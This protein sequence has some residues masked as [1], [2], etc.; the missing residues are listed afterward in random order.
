M[1]TYKVIIFDLF[2]TIV[3]FNRSR[4]PVTELNG[5][6]IN[7]TSPAVYKVFKKYCNHV[8]FDDFYSA[9][10]KSY[11]E[12]EEMKRKENLEF[13]NKERFK[14]MLDK[15]NI[16]ANSDSNKFVEEMVLCHMG[17]IADAM[18]FP[19]ENRNTLNMLRNRYRLA[20]IS[21]FDH[22]PTA[23]KILDRF[24][25]EN[26]FEKILISIEVGFRKPKADIF[27]KA[28]IHLKIKPDEA[29]FVGDNFEADV[30]GSKNA[31]MDIIWVNKGNEKIKHEII[32]PYYEV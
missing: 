14:L 15:L 16:N 29:I 26:F 9:F 21:N 20:L 2:D 3:I 23:Y 11:E 24:G 1:R 27:Q 6:Q 31:G 13:H 12:F 22:A 18:E 19:E 10:L 32:N 25:I 5:S 8:T 28:F 7:S 17:K 30:I 4:L